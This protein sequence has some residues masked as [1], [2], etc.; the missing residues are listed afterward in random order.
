ML[1]VLGAF[2]LQGWLSYTG[3]HEAM[4]P[5]VVG[6]VASIVGFYFGS[7]SGNGGPNGADK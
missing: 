2:S 7:R 5:W 3:S 1:A 6:L 4:P